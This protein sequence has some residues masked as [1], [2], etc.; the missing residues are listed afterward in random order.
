MSGSLWEWTL[1]EYQSSYQSAPMR[2]DVY[3][4]S[5][6]KCETRCAHDSVKRV[7]R[8]GG[9]RSSPR[10]LKVANRYGGQGDHRYNNV[11]FR[12][13]LTITAH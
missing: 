5:V 12:P 9:W 13:R 3:V 6:P 1:D 2:A 7:Y 4:G 11:G 8:G 10:D